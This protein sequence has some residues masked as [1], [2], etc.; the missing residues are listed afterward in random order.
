MADVPVYMVVHLHIEDS[1]RYLQYEKG[2]FPILKKHGGQFITYDDATSTFEGFN[3]PDGRIV[4][5]TFPSE[6]AAQ[7]WYNDP[8]Y[9][10][11]SEHRRAGTRLEFLTLV[12]GLPPR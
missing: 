6:E 1:D 7:D 9:Q 5:F 11:L 12:H 4:L 2:F 3:A 10:A 8:E